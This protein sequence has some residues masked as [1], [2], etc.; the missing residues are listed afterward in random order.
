MKRTRSVIVT[1]VVSLAALVAAGAWY[2]S[3]ASAGTAQAGREAPAEFKAR[4]CRG[5]F[6]LSSRTDRARERRDSLLTEVAAMVGVEPD[7]L[8]E[9]VRSVLTDRLDER[10]AD[11]VDAGHLTEDRARELVEAAESGT[12]I[13][14]LEQYAADRSGDR[15]ARR[16]ALR[17]RIADRLCD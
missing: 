6:D 8:E 17:D 12:L 14:V 9:A 15:W 2:T 11:A 16:G 3:S 1:A 10:L 4:I 5:E 7:E 13:D